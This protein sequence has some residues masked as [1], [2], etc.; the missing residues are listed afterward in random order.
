MPDIVRWRHRGL[1]LGLAVA[2]VAS[3]SS[4]A[5]ARHPA[6]TATASPAVV[7]ATDAPTIVPN[8]PDLR[9]DVTMTSCGAV[10]GGWQASGRIINHSSAARDYHVEVFFTSLQ[11]TVLGS[12]VIVVRIDAGASKAWKVADQFTPAKPTVC[13]VTGVS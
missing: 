11:T 2:V 3:L 8:D 7:G 13:V 6:P 9:K 12:G 4:C 5:P 10:K 1:A